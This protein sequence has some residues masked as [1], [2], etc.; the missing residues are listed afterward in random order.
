MSR[1]ALP[2][3][4]EEVRTIFRAGSASQFLLYGNVF[5][6]IPA[7]RVSG[8]S[9][10]EPPESP[11]GTPEVSDEAQHSLEPDKV[12][13][14]SQ[15]PSPQ[16]ADDP[17]DRV[18]Y[19]S[20]R[21]FLSD[22]MLAPFDTVLHYD[23][24]RGIRIYRGG[25]HFQAF[26]KAFD[27]FQ[28]SSWSSQSPVG[29]EESSRDTPLALANLLPKD[30]R[31]ALELLD[32]FLRAS[33]H[34]TTTGPDG[35]RRPDPLK[36]AVLL[37]YVHF[38]A[39]QGEALHLSGEISQNLIR[40]LD[41]GSDPALTGAHVATFLITENLADVNRLLVESPYS[42]QVKIELPSA[43]EIGTYV[44]HLSRGRLLPSQ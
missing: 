18:H 20:L 34:R 41:W 33:P 37:D 27:T 16:V 28:G 2:S 31:R 14:E 23:R 10:D 12:P 22:T 39:P 36:V 7:P 4:A 5:D 43:D 15:S 17:Q 25:E 26:L 6:L 30:P 32:R 29:D 11:E 42:A 1:Y 44:Y 8:E 21:R 13:G 3:W 38:I 9:Q 19:V 35:K 40:L 24:G